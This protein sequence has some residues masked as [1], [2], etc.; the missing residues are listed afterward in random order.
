MILACSKHYVSLF[1]IEEFATL[2]YEYE[3]KRVVSL[4]E[5]HR[6]MGF[7]T[8]LS[9]AAPSVYA[10]L[11]G[12]HYLFD[13]VCATPMPIDENWYENVNEQKKKNTLALLE[14]NSLE[15]VVFV[16]DHHDDLPLLKVEKDLNVLVSPSQKTVDLLK[17]QNIQYEIM[18]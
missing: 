1:K 17:K 7:V 13:F 3:N 18:E 11:I 8:V 12:T 10:E 2:L 15:M 4:L 6:E 16:T 5:K 9:S 14:Q